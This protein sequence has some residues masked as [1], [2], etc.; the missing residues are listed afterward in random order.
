MDFNFFQRKSKAF[1]L[2]KKALL[3]IDLEN[4][5]GDKIKKGSEITVLDKDKFGLNI[6]CEKSGTCIRNVWPE[7]IDLIK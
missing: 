6:K 2:N 4:I 1:F 5:A 3:N 7:Y